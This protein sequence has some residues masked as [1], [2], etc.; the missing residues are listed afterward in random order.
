MN[1]SKLALPF[2]IIIA[3]LIFQYLPRY[4]IYNYKGVSLIE[5]YDKWTGEFKF[6][7]HQRHPNTKVKSYN[8]QTIAYSNAQTR[9][10]ELEKLQ[11]DLK[12]RQ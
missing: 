4:S 1:L 6:C 5:V 7:R 12:D 10:F 9:D 3:A 11:R 2:S 8:C